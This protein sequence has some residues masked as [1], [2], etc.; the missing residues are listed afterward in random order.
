MRRLAHQELGGGDDAEGG[1]VNL[2]IHP[3]AKVVELAA[4]TTEHAPAIQARVWEGV[5]DT[6]IHVH[7]FVT[8][9][10]VPLDAGADAHARFAA[11]LA[12]VARPSADVDAYPARLIL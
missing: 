11:E 5:T 4:T 7:L 6:G 12:E 2:T 3:T 8:R 1:A 9:V 10:A